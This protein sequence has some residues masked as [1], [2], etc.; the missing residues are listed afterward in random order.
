MRF[1][2][3]I[4][5]GALV[6]AASSH[7]ALADADF[8]PWAAKTTP[9][10]VSKDLDGKPFDLATLR[11]RVVVLNFWATWCVPCRDELPSLERLRNKLKGEPF[12]VITVNY[13]EFPQRI[14]PFMDSEMMELPVV[15]DTQKEA[16][17]A[18]NVGGL[19]MTVLIDAQGRARYSAFGER[20]WDKGEQLALV[21][22]L[23][24]EAS[25]ARR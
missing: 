15:L 13:G 4:A 14:R 22:K 24:A 20:A 2:A 10:L 16:G 17:K 12:E 5:A 7:C 3:S 11:G 23:L 18:W 9:A 25:R 21:Q 1:K 6:L 8:R 19:P